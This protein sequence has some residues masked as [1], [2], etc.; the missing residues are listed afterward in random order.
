M[1]ISTLMYHGPQQISVLK[2]GLA[3]LLRGDGFTKISDAVG[4]DARN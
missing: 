1:F 3:E 2:R 4:V